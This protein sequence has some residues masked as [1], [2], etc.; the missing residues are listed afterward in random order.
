M[1]SIGSAVELVSHEEEQTVKEL[2]MVFSELRVK[3]TNLSSSV[4]MISPARRLIWPPPFSLIKLLVLD[5][6]I[7]LEPLGACMDDGSTKESYDD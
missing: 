3:V 6:G 1:K 4:E 5:T 7:I 2:K